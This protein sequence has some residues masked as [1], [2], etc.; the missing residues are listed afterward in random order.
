MSGED[1]AATAGFRNV[2]RIY[3]AASG[4]V[5]AL[6]G[7]DVDFPRG[8]LT[9]IAG[10]SGGGKSTLLSILSLRDRASAGSVTLFGGDVTRARGSAL[11][12]LRRTGIA[13]V[14]QR[15]AHGLFPHLTAMENLVQITRTR[16]RSTGLEPGAVLEMLALSH[17]AD[18]RP[19]RLSGGEQ[20]RLAIAAA[21]THAPDLV[22]ADEPTAELDDENAERVIKA[23]TAIAAEGTTCVLSTH[24]SRALRQL[25]RVLHLRHGVLSAE[26]AGVE[27]N[28]DSGLARTADAVIDSAG[29]LQ[30]PPDA[31][32]LFP[33]RRATVSIVGGD[34]VL[35]SPDAVAPPEPS[36]VTP[37]TVPPAAT[38]SSPTLGERSVSSTFSPARLSVTDV[39]HGVLNGV[40]LT[41]EPGTLV[42]LTGHSGSGKSTLC[43]LIAGFERPEHGTVT[44]DTQPTADLANWSRIAVVPQRLALLG[45]LSGVENLLLPAV[46]A[47]RPAEPAQAAELLERL[48]VAV[49]ASRPVG[50]GSIGE[51][52]R[53]AVARS[54]LLTSPLIVLDEPTAHQDDDNARRVI[55]AVLIAVAQGSLV[56]TFTHDPRVLT[57]ATKTLALGSGS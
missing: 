36:A 14:P 48:G 17:R 19:S 11:K 1:Q 15:P 16:G 6:R 3:R 4:E 34:V 8:S 21:L 23:L 2:V 26:R 47:A 56:I 28:G 42:G 41:A 44:L 10:P 20:Q 13:W 39:S 25:P 12:T 32:H 30:L 43:H 53:V 29:R 54:L 27:L 24:D 22:V 51:Q 40:S 52:Q 31:L 35:R 46:A 7:V 38:S 50:Q 18:A 55:D 57:H 33:G 5:H 37:D 49:L 45:E 9:A